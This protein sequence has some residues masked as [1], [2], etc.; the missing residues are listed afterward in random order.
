[1]LDVPRSAFGVRR[2]MFD[3]FLAVSSSAH[4]GGRFRQ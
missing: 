3:V 1:M 4:F 2:S